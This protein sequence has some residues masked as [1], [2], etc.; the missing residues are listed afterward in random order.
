MK[1]SVRTEAILLSSDVGVETTDWVLESLK[2]F[3]AEGVSDPEGLV[4]LKKFWY[5]LDGIRSNCG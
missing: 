2:S 3:E 1:I 5:P 4:A